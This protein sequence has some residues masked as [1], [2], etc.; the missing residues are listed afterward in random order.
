MPDDRKNVL[1]AVAGV[2][3]LF[4]IGAGFWLGRRGRPTAQVEQKDRPTE[5]LIKVSDA[6][7]EQKVNRDG[8]YTVKHDLASMVSDLPVHIH[9]YLFNTVQ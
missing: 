3:G 8:I 2:A 4:G 9:H 6:L 1:L 7:F 5:E